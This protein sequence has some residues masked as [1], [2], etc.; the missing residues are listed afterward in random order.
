VDLSEAGNRG[1][2]KRCSK[3]FIKS[4]YAWIMAPQV[5][6]WTG[7]D[8]GF[9]RMLRFCSSEPPPILFQSGSKSAGKIIRQVPSFLVKRAPHPGLLPEEREQGTLSMEPS[10]CLTKAE[11]GKW[12]T[13][14]LRLRGKANLR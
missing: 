14:S 2:K 13:L 3:L 8:G 6:K 10:R 4:F 1:E 12:E 7:M 5:W 11:R 9:S